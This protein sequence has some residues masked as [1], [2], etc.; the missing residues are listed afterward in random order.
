M[1]PKQRRAAVTHAQTSAAIS[2]PLSERRACRYLG[3]HRALCRYR[4]RR[5]PD[6]ALRTKLREL[7][8]A[9]PRWGIPRLTWLLR[10]EG[11]V[12]NHKRVERL[13][14]E[15]GLAVRRRR[16]RKRV[17]EPRVPL[18]EPR[19]ASQRWSMDF[20]RD[21][22]A[23]GRVFGSSRWSTISRASAR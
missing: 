14:R 6:T 1:T 2:E 10:R 16:G 19:A 9:H 13:Y 21:T 5:D 12:I 18:P 8:A 23:D 22:L 17:A 7:V 11:L 15:E 4:A 20:M 3:I